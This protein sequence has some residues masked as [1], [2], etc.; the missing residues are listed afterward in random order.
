MYYRLLSLDFLPPEEYN[1]QWLEMSNFF[2]PSYCFKQS[3]RQKEM[4]HVWAVSADAIKPEIH[5]HIF[6]TLWLVL[7]N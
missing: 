3:I 1:E 7:N 6:F 2:W 4:Q 5:D